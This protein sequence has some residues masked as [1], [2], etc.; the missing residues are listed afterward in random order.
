MPHYVLKV[1]V[2][3]EARDDLEARQRAAGLVTRLPAGLEGIREIVLQA[4]EERKSIR[5]NPDG[6]FQGQWNKGGPA[7]LPGPAKV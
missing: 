1:L 3:M 4:L 2:D 6:S 5:L 7:S